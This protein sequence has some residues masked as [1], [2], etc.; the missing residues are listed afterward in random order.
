MKINY[1][2][3]NIILLDANNIVELASEVDAIGLSEIVIKECDKFKNEFSERGF[4]ARQLGRML[5]LASITSTDNGITELLTIEGVKVL[6]ISKKSYSIPKDEISYNDKCIVEGAILLKEMQHDVTFITNDTMARIY[7]VTLA[8]PTR[9]FKQV[10]HYKFEFTKRLEVSE[11]I[12]SELHH[13][14]ITQ[15]DHDYRPENYNYLFMTPNSE[16]I[17]PACIINGSIQIIGKETEAELR[18]QDASPINVD[19][20]LLARAIQEPTTDLVICD[21][22]AGSGKT[23]CA[24]SNA[25]KLTKRNPDYN[26]ILY[27]RTSIDDVSDE[28]SVGFLS[29]NEEKFAVY[30]HPI[31]DVVDTIVRNRHKDSK[32]KGREYEAMIEEHTQKIFKEYNIQAMTTLGMRGRT[33]S[34]C[35]AIIDEV[36]NFTPASL[37]K[38]LTRFGKNCKIILIG[39][40]RQIDSK[41]IT[42]Y[43]SGLSVVLNDAAQDVQ[44]PINLH[45]VPLPKVVRSKLTEYSE[46]LFTKSH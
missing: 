26:S 44:R 30:L 25:M 16:Q 46:S 9:D 19:Q 32:L 7:A 28:E 23:I 29:G 15:I 14:P 45:V 18:R 4:Q 33:F 12:F 27:I 39:S 11:E 35:I 38:V 22:K 41:Y 1:L 21:S 42:K 20:L 24:V 43:T 3:T 37:N 40:L 10:D 8:L 13:K 17:K 2:D 6:I 36:Q 34:N 31:N 5:Q